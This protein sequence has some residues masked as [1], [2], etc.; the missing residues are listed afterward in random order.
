MRILSAVGLYSDSSVC[1]EEYDLL[2]SRSALSMEPVQRQ[3][4][5]YKVAAP[6]LKSGWVKRPPRRNNSWN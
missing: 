5:S 1:E 4:G 2:V 6:V 3:S